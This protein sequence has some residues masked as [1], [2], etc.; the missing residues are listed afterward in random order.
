MT[1]SSAYLSKDARSVF[2]GI[3]DMKPAMQM[4]LGWALAA[5]TGA[6]FQQNT[7]FT[8]Y[9]LDRFDPAAEGFEP[10]QVDLT[11]RSGSAASASAPRTAA[12]GK[13]VAEL[14]GCVACHSV[15]GSTLGKVGP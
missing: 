13:R 14:M 11:P 2:V 5:A 10:L 9:E 4:R 6:H 7:Y 1:P 8:P 12:E 15:D 3:P